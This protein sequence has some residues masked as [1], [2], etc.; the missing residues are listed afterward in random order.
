MINLTVEKAAHLLG[1]NQS[2]SQIIFK[3]MSIDSRTLV[4]QNLFVAI[5]GEQVDGHDFISQAEQKG[6]A[7]LLVSRPVASKLPQLI[8]DDVIV[9]LGKLS[10]YWRN[11]FTLPFIGVTGSNGKTTLK[12]MLASIL[13]AACNGQEESILATAGNLNNHFGLPLTLARLNALHR[14]AVIEMGMN[15]FGEIAYLSKLTRPQIAVITNAAHSHTA[16]V[17]D[18][19]GVAHAKAEIFLGLPKEGVAI[20]NRD[21]VYYA[22]WREQARQT[23]SFG[24]HPE[25]DIHLNASSNNGLIIL[26]TPHGQFDLQLPLLGKHNIHNAL[27]ATAAA[28]A[29]NIPLNAIKTGLEQTQA[30]PGRLQLHQLANG[31]NIIDD[32]YNANPFSLHAAINTLTAFSGKKIL[33][34][35]D[36]KELGPE[37]KSHHQAA[38][39]L[40]RKAGIDSLYTYGNLSADAALAFG[41]G[42]FHFNEQEKLVA[43]LKPLLSEGTTVLI[44]GSRSMKM[45]KVVRALM[46]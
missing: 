5:K 32:T 39:Q 13:K 15:H 14:Y 28:L 7:A 11:Q 18:V 40:V 33:V 46:H 6:A 24:F 26:N 35:G 25:A 27:A 17:G 10:Q 36:M 31:I 42:A 16:G 21:D 45:E 1:L 44:K 19:A 38:G 37:E 12:N 8:V 29:L 34:L 23:M 2:T 3:G 41:D 4:S 30:E 43:A 22:Y 9:S 20:L